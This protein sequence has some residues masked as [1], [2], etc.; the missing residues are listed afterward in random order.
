MKFKGSIGSSTTVKAI[1]LY[2][3]VV[4]CC[5]F[6]GLPGLFVQAVA[7]A[8]LLRHYRRCPELP[9]LTPEL[10]GIIVGLLLGDLN[11]ER[12][13]VN[14]GARLRFAQGSSNSEY[15][16]HL[17]SIFHPYCSTYLLPL[18]YTQ[19]L[20][21]GLVF[22]LILYLLLSSLSSMLSFILTGFK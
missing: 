21:V 8:N 19:I 13:S 2:R 9:P 12:W 7:A 14:G 20:M 1:V 6:T 17:Y 10:R 15:I 3:L 4:G 16:Y 11:A 22:G 18:R 5:C